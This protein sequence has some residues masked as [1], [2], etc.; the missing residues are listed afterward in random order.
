MVV[1]D[2]NGK[3]I[4]DYDLSKGYLTHK[5]KSVEHQ[6]V[7]DSEEQGEWVTIREY[8]ETGGKDVEWRVTAA[9]RGHWKTTDAGGVEV[10]DFDGNISDDWPHDISIPNIFEYA[11]YHAYTSTELA[12]FADKKK[13]EEQARQEAQ[14]KVE[15]AATLPDAIADLSEQVSNNAIDY[16]DLSDAVAELSALVSNLVKTK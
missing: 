3:K 11:V 10:T 13:K 4:E 12:E 1:Y 6:W 2:E 15:I 5:S 16:S 8:P 7:V 9:E 14:E